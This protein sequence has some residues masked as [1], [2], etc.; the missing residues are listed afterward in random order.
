MFKYSS[1][2]VIGIFFLLLFLFSS[3]NV[4][5]LDVSITDTVGV[6]AR[7]GEEVIIVTPGGGGGA[8]GISLP[9]TGVRFSG[10]A[11]PNALVSLLKQGEVKAVVKAN[12]FGDFSI[13]LEEN[14]D[15][16]TL[17]SLYAEDVLGNRSL[18]IN[19]PMVVQVGFITHLSGIRFAPTIVTD[20]AQVLF[21]DYLT[22]SG[23]ALPK[24][25]MEITIEGVEEKIFSLSS[26]KEGSY[27]MV[28][29]LIS[30]PEGDYVVFINYVKDAR[31]SKL[32][33]F[34]IGELNIFNTEIMLNIPGDCN[35]DRIINLVDF[36]VLAFWYGKDNPPLCVDTNKDNIINLIDFSILAFYWTG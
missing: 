3:S 9:E 15:S 24:M 34:I 17:F 26:S 33:K 7:V 2:K 35:A 22:V 8:S 1:K 12:K 4:Y 28:L 13:T 29:P 14:Y 30:I 19:Y 5:G 16:N 32:V 20:K 18:L 10:Q 25:E 27:K 31:I 11:Y 23:Y 36:S 21:G 6:S